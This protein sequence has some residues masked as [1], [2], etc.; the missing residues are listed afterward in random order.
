MNKNKKKI[1]L[2]KID[3]VFE[4]YSQ[5]FETKRFGSTP[6][7]YNP[8]RHRMELRLFSHPLWWFK[9]IFIVCGAVGFPYAVF[10]VRHFLFLFLFSKSPDKMP[11]FKVFINCVAA[12]LMFFILLLYILV[13]YRFNE[14]IRLQKDA[15]KLLYEFSKIGKFVCI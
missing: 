13:C 9:I 4:K 7:F 12:I 11:S 2:P 14:I 15:P 1:I 8:K 3:G 6:L 10:F 5:I